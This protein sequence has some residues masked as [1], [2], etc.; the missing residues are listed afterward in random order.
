M[1]NQELMFLLQ[2]KYVDNYAINTSLVSDQLSDYIGRGTGRLT[3][4]NNEP[5]MYAIL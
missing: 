2:N 1:S 5:C 3:V 4:L